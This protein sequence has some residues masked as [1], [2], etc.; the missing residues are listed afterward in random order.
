MHRTSSTSRAM[1]TAA[2]PL[3]HWLA[4]AASCRTRL[5]RLFIYKPCNYG[6][7]NEQLGSGGLLSLLVLYSRMLLEQRH[8]RIAA[9]NVER[10]GSRQRHRHAN[11]ARVCAAGTVVE[12][13]R[14][15]MRYASSRETALWTD[16]RT[17]FNQR[18]KIGPPA[19]K[20]RAWKARGTTTVA[21]HRGR[22]ARSD[23]EI[24]P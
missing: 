17:V 4:A 14:H 9:P 12:F 1:N 19:A 11:G 3:K 6:L 13:H 8:G 7:G 15:T 16:L 20:R 10:I 2:C 5:P 24:V 22:T 18:T 23:L 21:G